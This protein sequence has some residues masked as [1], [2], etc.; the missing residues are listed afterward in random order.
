MKLTLVI[1]ALLLVLTSADA[2]QR[3][4]FV[5]SDAILEKTPEYSTIQQQVNTLA[6]E[7]E[8]EIDNKRNEVDRLFREYQSRELL[9]TN[10]ERN[11]KRE[12]IVRAEED[13]ERLRIKYFGPEGDLFKQQESL[14]RPLQ[15]KIL[16]A[17]E[18]VAIEE[19]YDYVFDRKGDFLFMFAREQYDL[20]ERVL[21]EL[22]I[23]TESSSGS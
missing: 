20:S 18:E 5:D 2:Q 17:I 3:I 16:A 10:E 23:E 19:G 11:R 22:G 4:G 9:Y 12:E 15:E 21:A 8:T 13:I 1:P 14:M 7:W 6:R